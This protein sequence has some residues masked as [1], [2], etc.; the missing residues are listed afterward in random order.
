MRGIRDSLLRKEI[1]TLV[2]YF[3]IDGFTSP[4]F[5]DFTYFFLMNVVGISKFMYAMMTLIG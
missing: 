2:I 1:Y 5:G 3:L 4:S